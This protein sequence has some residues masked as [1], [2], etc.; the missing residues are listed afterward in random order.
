MK[1][2]EF[3][4]MTTAEIAEHYR[5]RERERLVEEARAAKLRWAHELPPRKIPIRERLRSAVVRV[6]RDAADRLE[7]TL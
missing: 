3:Q 1:L 2:S 4:Q 5:A 7:V 6:L